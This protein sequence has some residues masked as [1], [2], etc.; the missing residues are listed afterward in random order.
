VGWFNL[1]VYRVQWQ[2]VVS[3]VMNLR[4]F[5]SVKNVS[6]REGITKCSNEAYN[7]FTNIRQHNNY[8]LEHIGYMFRPVNRS[9]SGLIVTC[10]P[11]IYWSI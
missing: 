11:I 6:F 2:A 3:K 8:L 5:L 1:V 9:S 7:K 10:T 4:V